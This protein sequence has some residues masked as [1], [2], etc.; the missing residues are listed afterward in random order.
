MLEEEFNC[1][2]GADRRETIRANSLLNGSHAASAQPSGTGNESESHDE[3]DRENPNKR[4]KPIDTDIYNDI[5]FKLKSAEEEIQRQKLI[6]VM[7]T[8]MPFF[9]KLLA[10]FYTGSNR[11]KDNLW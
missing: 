9:K 8:L 4:R 6:S 1:I 11:E 5:V 2:N 10:V 7:I 3:E